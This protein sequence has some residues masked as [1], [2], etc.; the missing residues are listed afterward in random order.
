[1]AGSTRCQPFSF[2]INPTKYTID[3]KKAGSISEWQ[4]LRQ[5]TPWII[6]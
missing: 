2:A 3:P 4:H 6:G 5:G 1:M